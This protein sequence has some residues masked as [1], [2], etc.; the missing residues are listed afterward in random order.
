V[1]EVQAALAAMA[2]TRPTRS[3]PKA[4]LTGAA[5]RKAIMAPGACIC[6]GVGTRAATRASGSGGKS[7]SAAL[8]EERALCGTGSAGCEPP[9]HSL[10]DRYRRGRRRAAGGLPGW[11]SPIPA[12]DQ[13]HVA[14]GDGEVEK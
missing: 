1:D 8:S 14:P 3:G 5:L 6:G 11:W 7:A 10:P 9:T 4:V 2:G 13:H 12:A